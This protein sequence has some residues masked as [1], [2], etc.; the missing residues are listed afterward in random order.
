MTLRVHRSVV[1]DDFAAR[2]EAYIRELIAWQP[3][4]GAPR[5][6]APDAYV[7]NAIRIERPATGPDIY[8]P[9][10]EL[11]DDAPPPPSPSML[12]VVEMQKLVNAEQEEL[13]S[14]A[15][16]GSA[17]R[18]MSMEYNRAVRV[19]EADRTPEQVEAIEAYH[20]LGRKAEEI[21]YQFAKK[22]AALEASFAPA[23]A[24]EKAAAAK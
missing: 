5:P 8:V 11:V 19:P 2:V 12:L 6:A 7:E 16:S 21:Q 4:V 18:L 10:Y 13:N 14:L 23:I 24:A 3:L 17:Y 9:D 15:A 1:G 20:E 22:M